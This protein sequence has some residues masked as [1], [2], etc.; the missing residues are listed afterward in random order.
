MFTVYVIASE[1]AI[2]RYRDSRD[3][4]HNIRTLSSPSSHPPSLSIA[5]TAIPRVRCAP[6]TWILCTSLLRFLGKYPPI[7]FSRSHGE[8]HGYKSR[9]SRRDF[10]LCFLPRWEKHFF[11]FSSLPSVRS[12]FRGNLRNSSAR[13]EICFPHVSRSSLITSHVRALRV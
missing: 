11:E 6:C 4:P 8:Y 1:I 2:V 13:R 5:A 7:F 9:A 10:A 12:S 3:A